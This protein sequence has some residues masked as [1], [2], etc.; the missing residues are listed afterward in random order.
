MN[1]AVYRISNNTGR[2]IGA[3]L[4]CSWVIPFIPCRWRCPW[5][6]LWFRC[7]RW[8]LIRTEHSSRIQLK[9]WNL[10][11][12]GIA[13]VMSQPFDHLNEEQAII[14]FLEAIISR[15]LSTV[16]FTNV[17][18]RCIFYRRGISNKC[19]LA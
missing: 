11:Q 7:I 17:L 19:R 6:R 13:L 16:L 1:E 12:R 4:E 5:L 9:P 10:T 18:R 15:F 3:W 14:Y 2:T 8:L